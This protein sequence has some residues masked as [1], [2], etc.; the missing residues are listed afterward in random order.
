[1]GIHVNYTSGEDFQRVQFSGFT[2]HRSA[3]RRYGSGLASNVNNVNKESVHWDLGI[4]IDAYNGLP[5]AT[6]SDVIKTSGIGIPAISS[7]DEA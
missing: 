5:L 4:D 6:S 7:A 3:P 1:V 2:P